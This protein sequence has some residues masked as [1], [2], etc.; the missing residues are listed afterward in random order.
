MLRRLAEVEAFARTPV[1]PEQGIH[2]SA[3]RQLGGQSTG[4]PQRADGSHLFGTLLR[5]GRNGFDSFGDFTAANRVQWVGLMESQ[6]GSEK[7]DE[8]LPRAISGL[9]QCLANF[10]DLWIDLPVDKLPARNVSNASHLYRE[11]FPILEMRHELWVI[12]GELI[13]GPTT[14]LRFERGADRERQLAVVRRLRFRRLSFTATLTRW[15]W[16]KD[17]CSI[18]RKTPSSNTASKFRTSP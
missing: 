13:L 16:A 11:C 2:Q 10:S 4:W 18:R 17:S 12:W 9:T 15:Y 7:E 1:A 3:D 14:A 5:E 6:P 8:L